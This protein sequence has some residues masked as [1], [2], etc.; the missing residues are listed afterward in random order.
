MKKSWKPQNRSLWCANPLIYIILT[1]I[2]FVV[3]LILMFILKS[4]SCLFPFVF[5][6]GMWYLSV[7]QFDVYKDYGYSKL[8]IDTDRRMI[9]FDDVCVI[10]F[11]SI[12]DVKFKIEE[13]RDISSYEDANE[14]DY[15]VRAFRRNSDS[16]LYNFCASMNIITRDGRTIKF[17]IDFPNAAKDILNNIRACGIKVSASEDFDANASGLVAVVFIVLPFILWVVLKML[18]K[19]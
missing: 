12:V 5:F 4:I 2:S 15:N 1:I 13:V 7:H 11:S 14:L 10:P 16:T 6:V 18:F 17:Y 8:T 9:I 19:F 3:G